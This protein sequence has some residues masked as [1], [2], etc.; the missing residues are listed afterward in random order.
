MR[1]FARNVVGIGR[2]VMKGKADRG[3]GRPPQTA[4]AL[5]LEAAAQ[6]VV[7]SPTTQKERGVGKIQ[8][9]R[10]RVLAKNPAQKATLGKMP[11]RPLPICQR[12][13]LWRRG[14]SW[15]SS[16]SNKLLRLLQCSSSSRS[17][18]LHRIWFWLSR[19]HF[20]RLHRS[21]RPFGR[22]WKRSRALAIARLPKTSMPRPRPW[23]V[24]GR[25][26]RRLTMQEPS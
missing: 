24:P 5:D 19:K 3:L 1:N 8:V 11:L 17:T 25:H 10:K 16:N 18:N 12:P 9:P 13:T 14:L 15:T 26:I 20:Q 21:L 7:P 22:P 2:N 4:T 23:V 6:G